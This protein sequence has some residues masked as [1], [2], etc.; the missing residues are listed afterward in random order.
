MLKLGLLLAVLAAA[1]GAAALCPIHG[2][3]VLARWQAARGP[4]DFLERG[5]AEARASFAGEGGRAAPRH[6]DAHADKPA[7]RGDRKRPAPVERH[8]DADRAALDR[9]IAEH[10][11]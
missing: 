5:W 1:V 10:A 4:A 8:T 9:I 6:L 7:P 3:T 2:R 11:N